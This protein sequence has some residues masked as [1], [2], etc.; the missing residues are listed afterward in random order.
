MG[1]IFYRKPA[2]VKAELDRKLTWTSE[3][4]ARRVLDSAIVNLGTYYA[5]VEHAKPDGTCDVWAAVFLIKFAG[6]D[7]GYKDMTEH[8][9][10]VECDCPERILKRLTPLDASELHAPE[11]RARC[12]ARIAQRKANKLRDGARVR[13]LGSYTVAS[14]PC[15]TFTARKVRGGWRF[16]PVGGGPA[17]RIGGYRSQIAEVFA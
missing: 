5:A 10:P 7:F 13:F 14:G 15:D 4:G 9:G 3:S 1:W 8:M 12:W 2:N 11:W 6:G 16:A 17:Y